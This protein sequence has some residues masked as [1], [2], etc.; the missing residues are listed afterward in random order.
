MESDTKGVKKAASKRK[1]DSFKAVDSMQRYN[2]GFKINGCYSEAASC[3]LEKGASPQ[4]PPKP[5]DDNTDSST[6]PDRDVSSKKN[7]RFCR[8]NDYCLLKGFIK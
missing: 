8:G 6:E 1:C 2:T 3:Y 4:P 7:F 5:L